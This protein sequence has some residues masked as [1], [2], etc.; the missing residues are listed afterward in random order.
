MLQDSKKN[1]FSYKDEELILQFQQGN[2]NAYI[3]LVNRYKNKLINFTF[4]YLGDRDLAEDI[5]QETMLKLYE[6]RHYYKAIAKFS[7]WIYTIARNQANTELRKRKRR[8]IS[9]LSQ[10]T[11]N[12]KDFDLD[13]KSPDLIN[14]LQN[15]Y[16]AKRINKAI[17]LL[18]EHFREVIVLRDIQG[19][20]Y[21]DIGLVMDA[22]LGTIKSRI[23]RARIQLQAELH[24]LKKI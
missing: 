3:E 20:S 21:E 17:Q 11:K 2:E 6:K 18:P 15:T 9:F 22:P 8:N 1:N 12:G 10:M 16:L 24:D 19:L 7:T 23:N 5:V 14:E 4:N 13:S